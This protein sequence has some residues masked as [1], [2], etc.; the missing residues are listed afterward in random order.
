MSEASQVFRTLCGRQVFACRSGSRVSLQPWHT[1]IKTMSNRV[2]V[3]QVAVC[4]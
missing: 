2:L 3:L 1:Y 4:D